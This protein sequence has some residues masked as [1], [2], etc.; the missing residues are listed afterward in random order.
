MSRD[1]PSAESS[2]TGTD[3]ES[4]TDTEPG[5]TA[6]PGAEGYPAWLDR[7]EYPFESNY[8]DVGPGRLHYVDEGEGRPIL[9]LHGNPTWSFLYRTAIQ[10]LSDDHRCVAPDYFGFGLSEKPRDWSYRPEDHARAVV[11]FVEELGL[12]DVTLVVHDWGGPLG[13]SYAEDHPEN[14]HSLV[15]TNSW[16]WPVDDRLR[17][18]LWSSVLGGPLGRYFGKR[19]NFMADRMLSMGVAE[20]ARLPDRIKAHYTEPLADPA[21]R[22]GTWTFAREVTGSSNWL[23][24][25]WDRRAAIAG[26]PALLCWGTRDRAFGVDA[27]RTWQALYP[28]A[29]TVEF[30]D[31]SHYVPEEKGTRLAAEIREFLAES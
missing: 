6:E 11:E 7:S 20:R 24:D 12:A 4:G 18:R 15:V 10:E 29:R 25:L 13:V 17:Y 22:A 19:Y 2:G 8:L 16:C 30:A 28:D 31:A 14:V 9:F 23:A 27:L 1:Q 3:I 21:E 5:T 26:L